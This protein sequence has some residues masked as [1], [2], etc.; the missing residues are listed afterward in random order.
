MRR[1]QEE[2]DDLADINNGEEIKINIESVGVKGKG[3]VY[4]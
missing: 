3:R 2:G 4:R 1:Q